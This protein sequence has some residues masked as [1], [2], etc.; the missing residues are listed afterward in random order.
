ME[1][2]SGNEWVLED[3][4]VGGGRKM[5]VCGEIKYKGIWFFYTPG[6]KKATFEMKM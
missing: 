1:W 4:S 6:I 3:E 5:R 2:K